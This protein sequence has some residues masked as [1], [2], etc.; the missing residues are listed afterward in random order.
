MSSTTSRKTPPNDNEF[1]MITAFNATSKCPKVSIPIADIS[2]VI[3]RLS[4]GIC[5]STHEVSS[6]GVLSAQDFNSDLTGK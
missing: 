5:F 2:S 1:C 6:L 3:K 4:T